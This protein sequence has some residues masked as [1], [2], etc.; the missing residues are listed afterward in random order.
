MTSGWACVSERSG[1]RRVGGEVYAKRME[2][3]RLELQVIVAPEQERLGQVG[4]CAA[5]EEGAVGV[6]AA[7]LIDARRELLNSSLHQP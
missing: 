7:A 4:L 1:V 5:E 6:Q 2:R 3:T